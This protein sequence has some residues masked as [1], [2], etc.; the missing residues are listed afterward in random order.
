MTDTVRLYRDYSIY[1]QFNDSIVSQ[2]GWFC[3]EQ[4]GE[5]CNLSALIKSVFYKHAIKCVCDLNM[6]YPLVLKL[7]IDILYCGPARI[8]RL[9][10]HFFEE[11]TF[12]ILS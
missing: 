6:D 5:M 2:S 10:K 1:N 9:I 12:A 7:E 3:T 11:H 8:Q 4:S